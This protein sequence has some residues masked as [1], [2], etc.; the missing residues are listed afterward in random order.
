MQNATGRGPN[1]PGA[2]LEDGWSVAN[3]TAQAMSGAVETMGEVFKIA[4]QGTAADGL[5]R[6][7]NYL[8]SLHFRDEDDE[9]VNY[10]RWVERG[11]P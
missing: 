8:V 5:E 2:E 3:K 4:S 7:R 6:L 10:R 1:Q 11:R 9:M